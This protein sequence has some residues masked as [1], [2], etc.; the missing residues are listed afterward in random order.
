MRYLVM[1]EE[2]GTHRRITMYSAE[3]IATGEVFTWGINTDG[4]GV[5][6]WACLECIQL[7]RRKNDRGL[8]QLK[9]TLQGGK[10]NGS[11]G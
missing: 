9:C 2:V 3:W 6:Y 8:A 5:G 7:H 11:K 10:K 4:D 1:A